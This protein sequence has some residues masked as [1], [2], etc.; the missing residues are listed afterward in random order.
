MFALLPL[1]GGLLLGWLTPRRTAVGVQ[2]ILFAVAIT[3]VTISAPAHGASYL[4]SL[5]IGPALA[6]VSAGTLLLGMW[7]RRRTGSRASAQDR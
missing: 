7:V 3:M 4:D 2:V 5:W 1:V 6:V